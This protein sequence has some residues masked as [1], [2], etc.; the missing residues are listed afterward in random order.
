MLSSGALGS[1][2]ALPP[3]KVGGR[4]ASGVRVYVVSS[5]WE[6]VD[7]WGWGCGVLRASAG[8]QTRRLSPTRE[9]ETTC[10]TAHTP[11]ARCTRARSLAPR[12]LTAKPH[13][14]PP[15]LT[16]QGGM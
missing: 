6:R 10:T 11:R 5:W 3:G 7:P 14:L 16:I 1:L 8:T 12:T 9:K 4:E 2:V 15:W 13:E